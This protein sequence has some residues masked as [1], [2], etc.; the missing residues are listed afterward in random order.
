MYCFQESNGS[1]GAAVKAVANM[2]G[3][4][5]RTIFDHHLA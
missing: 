1:S 4:G 3:M 5:T 2:I